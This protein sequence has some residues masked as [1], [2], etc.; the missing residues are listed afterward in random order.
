MTGGRRLP[1][2]PLGLVLLPGQRLPLH[3][4][5][6]RY[7]QLVLD[8]QAGD[9]LFGL[10]YRPKG[11]GEAD[12]PPGWAIGVAHLE[13]VETLPDGRSNIMVRGRERVTLE[14]LV[15]DPAPYHV[16]D[17][18]P[19]QDVPEDETALASLADA[20]RARFA[21]IAA[22]AAVIADDADPPPPMPAD[23]TALAFAV[24]AVIDLDLEARQS[25]LASRSA[26]ERLK[27]ILGVLDAALPALEQRAGVHRGAKRNGKG[28]H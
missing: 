25:L 9:G 3:I 26:K 20:V 11:V 15:P 7:R 16:A 27:S 23:P 10:A 24:A 19:L 2:F 28:P 18:A 8:L 12:M 5:E 13:D 21:R 14:R 4:F 22:A 17:V 1:L 6:P